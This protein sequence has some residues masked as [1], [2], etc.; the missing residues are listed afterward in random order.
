L[1]R[2]AVTKRDD[3]RLEVA[4]FAFDAPE[5]GPKYDW[6]VVASPEHSGRLYDSTISAIA[7]ALF[8]RWKEANPDASHREIGDMQFHTSLLRTHGHLFL[9]AC[10]DCGA[11]YLDGRSSSNRATRRCSACFARQ[12][13]S[14]AGVD[15]RSLPGAFGG[16][17]RPAILLSSLSSGGA[18]SRRREM[19][20]AGVGPGC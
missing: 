12:G 13:A 5:Y 16:T 6:R 2:I 17:I 14:K 11:L 10:G 19:T 9:K 7:G 15:L 4:G 8:K 18:P 3:G 1:T 20:I